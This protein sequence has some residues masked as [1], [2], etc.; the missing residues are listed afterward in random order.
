MPVRNYLMVASALFVLT[1]ITVAV[2]QVDFGAWNLV[3][4][5]VVATT[6][7]VLVAMFFMH[8]FYD[9]KLFAAF[10]T[11]SFVI[12]GI[13]IVITMF[14]TMERDR[15]Y[16]EVATPIREHAIIYDDEGKPLK[17]NAHAGEG[18]HGEAAEHG[19]AAMEHEEGA[20]AEGGDEQGS[21]DATSGGH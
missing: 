17:Q 18:E 3:V 14:D 16:P 8:L 21:E 19:D 1:V 20:A 6:K 10:F 2:A 5:M 13:F 7:A 12:L 9:N 15:L 11:G 4:A